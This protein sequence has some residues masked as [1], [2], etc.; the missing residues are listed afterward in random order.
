MSRTSWVRLCCIMTAINQTI[1]GY[2]YRTETPLTLSLRS[3]TAEFI[4]QRRSCS[5]SWS[6]WER[7]MWILRVYR[8][9]GA[10]PNAA[11]VITATIETNNAPKNDLLTTFM[12]QI[13]H[14]VGTNLF[15]P[16]ECSEYRSSEVGK[17][18]FRL[19]VKLCNK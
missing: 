19:D 6:L 9:A 5:Y 18:G 7:T 8:A 12:S 3:F 13:K 10:P 15:C 16:T 2:R 4:Q 1:I 14:I 17:K 11:V